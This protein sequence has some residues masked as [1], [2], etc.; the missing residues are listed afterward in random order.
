MLAPGGLLILTFHRVLA[1]PDPFLPGEPDRAAFAAQM[2]FLRRNMRPVGLVEGIEALGRGTLPPGAVAVTFDDGYANNLQQALPI[3]QQ[4]QVPATVFVATGL[5]DGGLMF[6]DALLEIARQA[7]GPAIDAGEL[8]VAP[9]AATDIPQRRLAFRR[10]VDLVKYRPPE[11]RLPLA[12]RLAARLGVTLPRDLMLSTA[13]LQA[14]AAAGVEVG[15]HT[16]THPILARLPS[17]A[18]AAEIGGSFRELARRLGQ[19]PRAFAYP[20]GRPGQDFGPE[21][22]AMVRSAGFRVAVTT[23]AGCARAGDDPLAMRRMTLWSRTPWR[24]AR[25]V[26]AGYLRPAS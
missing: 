8:G 25:N 1:E 11:E 12:E 19:P 14:L 4:F 26:V 13:Q 7:R 16:V 24:L 2:C 17:G 15:A 22:V 3:L 18:A 10:L 5:L 21:H 20:N 9:L 23:E 6:N